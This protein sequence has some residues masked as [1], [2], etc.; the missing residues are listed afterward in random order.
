MNQN[1]SKR[2]SISWSICLSLLLCQTLQL[3]NVPLSDPELAPAKLVP[4]APPPVD[5]DFD[6]V[7]NTD[8]RNIK[9]GYKY[10]E[11]NSQTQAQLVPSQ[12]SLNVP[13]DLENLQD[14]VK[15]NNEGITDVEDNSLTQLPTTLTQAQFAPP[16]PRAMS[17]SFP[18]EN[19]WLSNL[20]QNDEGSTDEEDNSL[21]QLPT[22]LT[23]AQFAPPK[24]N[25]PSDFKKWQDDFKQNNE[26]NNYEGNSLTQLPTALT[27]SK[28][29]LLQGVARSPPRGVAMSPS[30]PSR[31]SPWNMGMQER[32]K[33]LRRNFN[34]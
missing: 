20:E 4:H 7:Q 21:S 13:S 32:F 34:G 18:G 1:V 19:G 9:E 6:Y 3:P 16:Q 23:Q 17:Q 31:W 28:F 8:G 14:F 10:E 5:P 11:D 26:A 27:Q 15:Q 30:S 24:P 22:T 33:N 2:I 12:P 29:A 25:D